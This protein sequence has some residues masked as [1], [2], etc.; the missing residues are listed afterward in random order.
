MTPKTGYD[1]SL[2]LQKLRR[3]AVLGTVTHQQIA[4]A[5]WEVAWDLR[6]AIEQQAPDKWEE[7]QERCLQE[8]VPSLV[9]IV[10]AAGLEVV[11]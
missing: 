3:V 7:A 6:A 8:T 10:E 9:W 5:F 11:P 1:E 4:D 2:L